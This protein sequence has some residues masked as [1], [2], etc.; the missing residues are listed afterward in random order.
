MLISPEWVEGRRRKWGENSALF[1]SKCR[2]RFPVGASPW[3][4]VPITWA[5]ACRWL[6]LPAL[7]PAEAGLDVGAGSDRTV[8]SLRRGPKLVDMFTFVDADPMKSVGALVRKLTEWNVRRVKG[9]PIGVGWA[10]MGRL[11]ELSRFHHPYSTEA[12]HDAEV[13]GVNF[14]EAPSPGKE[15][16]YLN[17]RAEVWWEV[18]REN[19]RLQR[20]DL[21]ALDED[22]LQELTTPK[23]EIVDSKGKIKIQPKKE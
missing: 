14:A 21:A 12:C 23:Y 3:I 15:H 10:L 2:G 1:T 18:G 5:E 9:D 6:E 16:L 4:C 22:G 19:C 8:L 11:R 20:W 13:V 17:K 7:G